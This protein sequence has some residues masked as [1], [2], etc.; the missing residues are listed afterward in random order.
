MLTRGRSRAI[1]RDPHWYMARLNTEK[2]LILDFSVKNLENHNEAD[3]WDFLW[4]TNIPKFT[5][6]MIFDFSLKQQIEAKTD[7]EKFLEFFRYESYYREFPEFLIFIFRLNLLF[8]AKFEIHTVFRVNFGIFE[9]HGK[10]VQS[11]FLTEKS[12]IRNF[13]NF[14]YDSCRGIKMK[15]KPEIL[16]DHQ[17]EV[18][19]RLQILFLYKPLANFPLYL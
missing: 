11:C 16:V 13:K 10:S 14:V 19:E 3:L 6:H 17:Q 4:I 1:Q 2:F 12:R 7:H 15:T 5:L 9:I 18:F 8:S